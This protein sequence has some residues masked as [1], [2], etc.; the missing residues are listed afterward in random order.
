MNSPSA[1]LQEG[2]G[3][4]VVSAYVEVILD[5]RDRRAPVSPTELPCSGLT[6]AVCRAVCPGAAALQRKVRR[7]L[8]ALDGSVCRADPLLLLC[9][10]MPISLLS[11]HLMLQVDKD[12]FRIR[13]TF[14][15]KKDEYHVDKKSTTW[16]WAATS[17]ST[18]RKQWLPLDTTESEALESWILAERLPPSLTHICVAVQ[19][20]RADAAAGD[21][22]VL[23]V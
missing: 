20:E 21:G 8:R 12:E 16:V 14:G 7:T 11:P 10:I 4:A 15:A 17:C 23:Q 1:V 9:G 2:A 18:L 13:R 19:E 22:W 6:G 5:N 3:N